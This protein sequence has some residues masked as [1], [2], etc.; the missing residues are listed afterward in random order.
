MSLKTSIILIS[1]VLFLFN[2]SFAKGRKKEKKYRVTLESF[3]NPICS[4]DSFRVKATGHHPCN[5]KNVSYQWYANGKH[6][7][8]TKSNTLSLG[9]LHNGDEIHVVIT[10]KK[11]KKPLKFTSSSVVVNFKE[12]SF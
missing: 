1:C 4:T 8:T 5:K 11:H 10:C 2:F 12:C 9:T 3:E 7:T 6:L